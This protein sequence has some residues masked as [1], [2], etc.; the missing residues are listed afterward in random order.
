MYSMSEETSKLVFVIVIPN[1]LKNTLNL[2]RS[3]SK[4]SLTF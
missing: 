4:S 1:Y 2:A 3:D